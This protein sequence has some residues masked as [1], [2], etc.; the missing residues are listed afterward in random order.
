MASSSPFSLGQ[1]PFLVSDAKAVE[2]G[3]EQNVSYAMVPAGPAVDAAEVESAS[4]AVE[5]VVRWDDSILH[6]GHLTPARTFT[7][8]ED[9]SDVVLPADRLGMARAQLVS[10]E[11]SDAFANLLPGATAHI[12]ANGRKLSLEDATREGLVSG[13][14]IRLTQNVR[15]KLEL[16]GFSFET[17][18]VMA[19]KKVAGKIG[20]DRRA[21]VGQ[22]VSFAVHGAIAAAL[23]AF[24]PALSST[25]DGE[26]SN[27][28]RYSLQALLT[29]AEQDRE[30][31]EQEK[32]K[33]DETAGSSA[34]AGA[35]SPG[36]RGAMGSETAKKTSGAYAV[37]GQ[38]KERTLNKQELLQDAQTFGM[39]ELLGNTQTSI[40][41][42]GPT[43]PWG[44]VADGPDAVAAKGKMWG[45]DLAD[46]YGQGG[47]DLSGVGEGAGGKWNGIGM[48]GLDTVGHGSGTCVDANCQ[49]FGNNGG[50]LNRGHS[51]TS[52]KIRMAPP[53]VSGR[54]PPEVIQRVVRQSFGRF[55]GCYEPALR[56]NPNLAG[57]VS[58]AFT[59]GRDG[60]VGSAQNGGSDLPDS[61]VVNCIVKSFY[62][63]SFPA[64]E[65]GIV[66]VS[67]PIVLAP[68]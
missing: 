2:E 61:A 66:T 1:N 43:S 12:V 3:S 33:T 23:F 31:A 59:I 4:L 68:Q 24:M 6:I 48:G 52:P 57:R 27:D 64:P 14:K 29:D 19:G 35:P 36:E 13:D 11:G 49:G 41:S 53:S 25:E 67:Y 54:I 17:A 7:V 42:N 39:I 65:A 15:V 22:A 21:V 62:G 37:K 9:G 30:Q 51:A 40:A 46:A 5:V 58:V 45:D 34:G 44:E 50:H 28:Q 32:T 60:A 26:M 56:S 8:G 18:G 20:G 55:R 16:G 47:L 38:A 10:I 63:L